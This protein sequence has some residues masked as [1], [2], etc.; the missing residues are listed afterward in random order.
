MTMRQ[1]AIV[2]QAALGVAQPD[3]ERVRAVS[4]ASATVDLSRQLSAAAAEGLLGSV[5]AAIGRPPGQAQAPD[6]LSA[7]ASAALRASEQHPE[8]AFYLRDLT[9]SFAERDGQANGDGPLL[10]LERWWDEDRDNGGPL[11]C[12]RGDTT[13]LAATSDCSVA[14]VDLDRDG[15]HDASDPSQPMGALWVRLADLAELRR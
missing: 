11:I 9:R 6:P 1:T 12:Q 8:A 15:Y 10:R 2:L 5:A 7:V 13:M 3:P 14:Y 4:L